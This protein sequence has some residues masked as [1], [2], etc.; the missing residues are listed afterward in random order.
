MEKDLR[1]KIETV[2]ANG[3]SWPGDALATAVKAAAEQYKPQK[4]FQL[5]FDPNAKFDTLHKKLE[6]AATFQLQSYLDQPGIK[7]TQLE[8][9]TTELE[10]ALQVAGVITNKKG[11]KVAVLALVAAESVPQT[12]WSKLEGLLFHWGVTR[13]ADK[14]ELPPMGW[15]TLPYRNEDAGGAWQSEFEKMTIGNF[16]EALYTL[17]LELPLTG[18]LE[19]GSIVFVLKTPATSKNKARWLKDAKTT[20]DFVVNVQKFAAA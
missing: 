10:A 11:K 2:K 18:N 19:T 3:A 17:V 6:V 9:T 14:W 12:S 13:E 8:F 5:H 1:P 15:K 16:N 7:P 4:P 20:K